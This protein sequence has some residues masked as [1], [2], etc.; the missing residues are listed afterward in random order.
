MINHPNP[1]RG[2]QQNGILEDSTK[3]SLQKQDL[4]K[5]KKKKMVNF[6]NQRLW[7]S[8]WQPKDC[9]NQASSSPGGHCREPWG[10]STYLA[11]SQPQQWLWRYEAVDTVWAPG[12]RGRR[13]EG[14][15][16]PSV[17][18]LVPWRTVASGLALVPFTQ[19]FLRESRERATQR[20]LLRNAGRQAGA[21]PTGPSKGLKPPA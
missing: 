6:Q 18:E 2:C 5:K 10:L 19:K 8:G 12:S 17:W 11:P 9:S 7:N 4:K 16:S 14:I 1:K 21:G 13:A 3:L 15:Q 20:S